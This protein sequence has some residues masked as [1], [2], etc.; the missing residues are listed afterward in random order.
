MIPRIT[1]LAAAMSLFASAAPALAQTDQA[2]PAST[3]PALSLTGPHFVVDQVVVSFG[4]ILDTKPTSV[5]FLFRNP[6]NAP[7]RILSVKP[8][9]H[10]VTLVPFA[11]NEWA[12]GESGEMVFFFDPSQQMR[13]GPVSTTV[14]VSTNA[15][16][17]P[18]EL[19]ING[20]VNATVEVSPLPARFGW[21]KPG[22]A[23]VLKLVVAGRTPDFTVTK[24]RML[25]QP[26]YY[27]IRIGEPAEADLRGEK[28]RKVVVELTLKNMPDGRYLDE[29]ELTT[30]D[31]R[32]PTKVVVVSGYVGETPPPA[33]IAQPEIIHKGKKVP[34]E[35]LTR[36]Q[37]LSRP[38]KPPQQAPGATPPADAPKPENPPKP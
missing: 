31:P 37:I 6:G 34:T 8:L 27:D 32:V 2:P 16:G 38:V 4:T 17:K 9:S 24:A 21:S 13:A 36:E 19:R 25:R 30:N 29:V 3:Q 15:G 1:P 20:H 5:K 22:E 35:Q 7:L 26:D 28:G 23:K 11:K 12:P 33:Q 14:E 10:A 18:V